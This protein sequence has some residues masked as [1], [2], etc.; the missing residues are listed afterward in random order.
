MP[1]AEARGFFYA[2]KCAQKIS[3]AEGAEDAEKLQG[4]DE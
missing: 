2:L 1:L 4:E 3:T